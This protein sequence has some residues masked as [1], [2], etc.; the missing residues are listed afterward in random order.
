MQ[1]SSINDGNERI[2]YSTHKNYDVAIVYGLNG[3][4]KPKAIADLKS[5]DIGCL[6]VVKAIVVRASEIKP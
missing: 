1:V 6:V 3:K 4:A 5:D 2:P